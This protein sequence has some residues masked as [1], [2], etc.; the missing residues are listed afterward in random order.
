MYRDALAVLMHTIPP[1]RRSSY[2]TE[3][4]DARLV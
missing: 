4:L 2:E 3:N 1:S